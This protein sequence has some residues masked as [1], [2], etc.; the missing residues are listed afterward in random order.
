M[1]ARQED[2]YARQGEKHFSGHNFLLAFLLLWVFHH[3]LGTG[4]VEFLLVDVSVIVGIN[5]R[6]IHDVGSGVCLG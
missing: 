2:D 3:A 4:C 5:L 1:S 6:K